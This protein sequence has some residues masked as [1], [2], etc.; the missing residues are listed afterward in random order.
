MLILVLCFFVTSVLFPCS[1]VFLPKFSASGVTEEASAIE[2][3]PRHH[4]DRHMKVCLLV[5]SQPIFIF[6]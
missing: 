1:L 4:S 6:Y 5:I 2:A 3:S